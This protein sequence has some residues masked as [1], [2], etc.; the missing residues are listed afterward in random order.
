ME[1]HSQVRIEVVGSELDPAILCQWIDGS[2][3]NFSICWSKNLRWKVET[4][5]F[6]SQ[7]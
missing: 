6:T 3:G 5:V 2:E 1:L 4:M 7:I